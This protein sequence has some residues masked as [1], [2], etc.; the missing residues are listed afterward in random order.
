MKKVNFILM[1]FVLGITFFTLVD[2]IKADDSD[3]SFEESKSI[4]KICKYS[5][6]KV[7]G[8]VQ[9][10]AGEDVY[11]YIYSD[12]TAS[13]GWSGRWCSRTNS[14]GYC[15]DGYNSG[16]KKYPGILNWSTVSTKDSN[17]GAPDAYK[18]YK[19]KGECPGYLAKASSG[20]DNRFFLS[21]GMSASS[22]RAI[23]NANEKIKGGTKKYFY[24]VDDSSFTVE[25]DLSCEYKLEEDDSVTFKLDI[26]K[27]GSITTSDVGK[28]VS[29]KMFSSAY[30]NLL[31]NNK[32]P[33]SLATCKKK[34]STMG[35][36]T[37]NYYVVYG[38][39]SVGEMFCDDDLKNFLCQGEN[40]SAR[41]VCQVYSDY[42]GEIDDILTEYNGTDEKN[43][44]KRAQVLKKYNDKK[45]EL[46]SYCV[47][48]VSTLN[49]SEGNCIDMCL[50]LNRNLAGLETKYKLR[51]GLSDE[52]CN[53]S[54][55]VLNLV[56]NV[57]KWGKYIAPVLVIILSILDFIKAIASQN[58]D[59]MKKAQGKF[60][61]RLIIAA[62]LFLLPL[63]INFMLK[64]FGL[65]SSKCDITDLFG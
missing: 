38:D 24:S 32:C 12:K 47:S 29:K 2:I 1:M 27:D 13:V 43:K 19:D 7:I 42:E 36:G 48:V 49:Y 30:L 34:S 60:I 64:T 63:I 39:S 3:Y 55:S 51:S 16:G 46:N 21:A 45:S 57:L 53:V 31:E 52:N 25:N 65:Y 61:K 23:H 8:S 28:I 9:V 15:A 37:A 20:S 5:A 14:K 40:C 11:L 59:D 18:E 6:D 54:R 22:L 58:D 50:D 10:N 35:A 33:K 4:E 56:Y 26:T 41:D 17:Y 62:I 44:N